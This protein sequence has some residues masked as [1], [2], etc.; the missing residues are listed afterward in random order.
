MLDAS[1]GASGSTHDTVAR[2]IHTLGTPRRT[3][4]FMIGS[5]QV[6]MRKPR[7]LRFQDWSRQALNSR[8]DDCSSA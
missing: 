6:F 2:L 8:G 5:R 7:E 1:V 3:E 4:N